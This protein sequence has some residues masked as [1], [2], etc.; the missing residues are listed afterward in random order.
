[1]PPAIKPVRPARRGRGREPSAV[2]Q[3][4][5]AIGPPKRM[6]PMAPQPPWERGPGGLLPQG[7][8]PAAAAAPIGAGRG[9]GGGRGQAVGGQAMAGPGG[10]QLLSRV[11]SGAI[12]QE[13]AEKTMQQRQTLEKAFG[14]DW[15]I[16]IG[17][18]LGYQQ[19]TRKALAKNPDNATL[20]ALNKRLEENRQRALERAR[21]K[22]GES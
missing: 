22:L 18:S 14:K 4:S 19:R 15:R 12:D 21:Q 11:R 2:A 5:S 1:M 6:K 9:R 7:E 20:A 10:A 17:G 13:Q 16:K 8:A 3:M